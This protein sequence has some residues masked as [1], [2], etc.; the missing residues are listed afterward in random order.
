MGDD[1]LEIA[2]R[3]QA[4]RLMRA[5]VALMLAFAIVALNYVVQIVTGRV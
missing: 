2:K 5:F 4:D 3:R 1:S